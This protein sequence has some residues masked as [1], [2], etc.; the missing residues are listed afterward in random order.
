MLLFSETRILDQDSLGEWIAIVSGLD[1][2]SDTTDDSKIHMLTEYLTGEVGG[3]VDQTSTAQISRLIVAG[4]SLVPIIEQN[5]PALERRP[6]R[7]NIPAE[8]I[9]NLFWA[10]AANTGYRAYIPATHPKPLSALI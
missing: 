3:T 9:T 10:A 7:L 2:G 8:L 5:E 1:I 6:V 4:N